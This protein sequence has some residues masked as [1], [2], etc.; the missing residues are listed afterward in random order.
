MSESR[1]N[2]QAGMM[3]SGFN[4]PA[5]MMEESGFNDQDGML[6]LGARKGR[7]STYPFPRP[8]PLP[9][10]KSEI[11]PW[12]EWG[13]RGLYQSQ[14]EETASELNNPLLESGSY[15]PTGMMDPKYND[16]SEVGRRRRRKEKPTYC[17]LPNSWQIYRGNF[18]Y[19]K[20]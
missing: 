6:E 10:Q 11:H 1:L 20:C 13:G 4:N 16:P 8:H 3:E 9:V 18:W 12:D 7:V 14:G 2:D 5:G 15:N 17:D 19:H